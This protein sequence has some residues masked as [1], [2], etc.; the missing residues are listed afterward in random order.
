MEVGLRP[1]PAAGAAWSYQATVSALGLEGYAARPRQLCLLGARVWPQA[2][3]ISGPPVWSS[4]G[5]GERCA[6]QADPAF[7]AGGPA[8]GASAASLPGDSLTE[9][10]YLP[11][12]RVR[13]DGRVAD[14]PG[15]PVW[16]TASRD[17]MPPVADLSLLRYRAASEVQGTAPPTL[18]TTVYL[19][20]AG[21]RSVAAEQGGCGVS[22]RV[23]RSPQR[24]G[25]PVWDSRRRGDV[26]GFSIIEYVIGR[27]M[28]RDRLR[29]EV[30][31][32]E[33]LGDSL[34]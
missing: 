7:A 30:P 11:V 3:G 2:R 28:P 14:L 19:S 29:Y 8:H 20:V 31:V 25:V 10:W 15:R 23:Y 5:R 17:T 18:R 21:P 22:V 4:M 33:M 1:V 16:V 6:T 34:A 13:A 27:G 9:G 24:T 12:V 32:P 26:C